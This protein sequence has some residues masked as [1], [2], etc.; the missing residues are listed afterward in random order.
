[1]GSRRWAASPAV[2]IRKVEKEHGELYNVASSTGSR[3]QGPG[4]MTLQ[5]AWSD[6]AAT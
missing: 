5:R 2:Y 4:Q 1:M 6:A 3:R